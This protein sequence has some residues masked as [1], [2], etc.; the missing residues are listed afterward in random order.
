[1]TE[2]ALSSLQCIHPAQM[3]DE[4]TSMLTHPSL[5]SSTSHIICS[6]SEIPYWLIWPQGRLR[7]W[8]RINNQQAIGRM[9]WL[10]KFPCALC[11]LSSY[12]SLNESGGHEAKEGV[13]LTGS[14]PNDRS[15]CS[16][17]S[18]WRHRVHACSIQSRGK[19]MLH[20]ARASTLR[21]KPKDGEGGSG[22]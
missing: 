20:A 5:S 11:M 16:S 8:Q 13:T 7:Q 4:N 22:A 12:V 18:P 17:C 10:E 2:S 6:T 19:N 15:V 9:P 3:I 1:M 21:G 14:Y